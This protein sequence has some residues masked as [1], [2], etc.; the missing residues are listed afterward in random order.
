[1]TLVDLID[2]SPDLKRYAG[3]LP[4]IQI[5]ER[6]ACD[7]ELLATGA[8]SPLDRFMSQAAYQRVLDEMRLPSGDVFPIP[9]TLP[10][11]ASANVELHRDLA[12]RN[13]RND[14]LA[15]MTV[16]EI[17]GWDAEEFAAKVLGTTDPKHPL[18]AES[19]RWGKLNIS[20]PLR[21]LPI[22][23]PID[24]RELR[25]TP[26]EVRALL[27]ATGRENV[28]A[29]QT[30][31][32]LHRVHEELTRR[33]TAAVDG[34][35]LLHPVVGLT[36]P[37]DVDHYTRVR[38]Y[39]A[40][41]EHHYDRDRI[42]LSLLPL[43][44]RM[45]GPREA[46]WHALIRKNYGA[47]HFIVG[48][49]HA[50]PGPFYGPYDAQE[51]VA[52]YSDEIGV[53]MVPFEELVYL[54]DEDRYEEAS[55]VPAGAR[56]LTISGTQVRE[57]YLDRGRRLPEWFTRPEVARILGESYPPRHQ[58]GV[59]IWFTGFSGAGKTATAELLAQ[60]LLEH[61]RQATMLDGDVVR[62]HLSK[63]LGFSKE[64]RD[65]N[66]RRI[67]FVAAEIVRHGGIAI[68]AAVSPYRATREETRRMVGGDRF[69]EV[70]VDTPLEVCESRD[71]KGMYAQARS[72]AIKGFTGIDDPYEAPLAAEVTLE[73]T[74][75]TAEDNARKILALVEERG[76]V[77]SGVR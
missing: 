2:R 23:P 6:A 65:T 57:Q 38:T 19:A 52:R 22:V 67:G 5:S 26:A 51:L 60:L 33:A 74:S 39:K 10:V 41:A 72:G 15:V 25:R 21:V 43:A 63:G 68:C 8:F 4:S 73:T 69:L 24:F 34:V 18:V 27:A 66:I 75:A 40:L 16:E 50:S 1:M 54:P 62:T 37:G 48:R 47:N 59:C 55:K 64:D 42:V 32:P 58:Q 45:A 76:F 36:K 13:S 3:T 28:V 35:L 44:M 9:V 31:N 61:G 17:Y 30:R 70:F 29:F 49:D 56:T 14:L 12:L 20:G 7:L 71:T 77:Q 53:K 11:D 46:L